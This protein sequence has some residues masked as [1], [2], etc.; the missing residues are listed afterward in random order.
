MTIFLYAEVENWRR[1]HGSNM[2]Y[3]PGVGCWVA[4]RQTLARCLVLYPSSAALAT[5]HQTRWCCCVGR[6]TS[7]SGAVDVSMCGGGVA[8]S[9]HHTLTLASDDGV[10]DASIDRA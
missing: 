7:A 6:W 9:V 5:E 4:W 1:S 3:F 2:C 10:S 8:L